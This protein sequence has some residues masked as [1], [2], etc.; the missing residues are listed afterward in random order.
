LVLTSLI[1]A[2]GSCLYSECLLTEEFLLQGM[3]QSVNG[4]IH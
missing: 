3:P 2:I 4:P 1:Q